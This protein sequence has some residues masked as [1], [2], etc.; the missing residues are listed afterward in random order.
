MPAVKNLTK[1]E[2]E[3]GLDHIRLSPKDGGVLEL[4]VRR[5]AVDEREVLEEAR[6]DLIKGLVG[7][8]WKVRGSKRTEDGSSHPEMQLNIM[9]ARSVALVAGERERWPLAGDQLYLD[10]DLSD[11]NLPPGSRL[12]IGAAIIEVTAIPHNGCLKFKARF[13]K[14]AVQFVNS[15][16]GKRLHLRGINAKIIQPGIIRQG[17]LATKL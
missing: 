9:N 3:A 5:P 12:A 10:L 17:D 7:D 2:L 13:G 4:I 6:L 14:E 1:A 16:V 15:D 11:E 8:T